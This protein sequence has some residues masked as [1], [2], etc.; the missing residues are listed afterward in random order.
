MVENIV[1]KGENAGHTDFFF[2]YMY[3]RFRLTRIDR[4]NKPSQK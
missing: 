3:S 2:S 1:R 4:S